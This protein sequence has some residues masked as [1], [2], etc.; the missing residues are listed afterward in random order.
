MVDQEMA[1]AA[2][3]AVVPAAAAAVWVVAI[4][5]LLAQAPWVKAIMVGPERLS[6]SVVMRLALAAAAVAVRVAMLL[7]Q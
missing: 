1:A 2:E 7:V 6:I 5:M 3:P 4:R